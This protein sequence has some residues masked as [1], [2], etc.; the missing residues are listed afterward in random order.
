MQIYLGEDMES[1]CRG[2]DII[3]NDTTYTITPMEMMSIFNYYME[4]QKSRCAEHVWRDVE[5]ALL[6]AEYP[7]NV[8]L[9]IMAER[10]EAY[11]VLALARDLEGTQISIGPDIQRA[12]DMLSNENR[13]VIEDFYRDKKYKNA[14]LNNNYLNLS[15][16][17]AVPLNFALGEALCA[18]EPLVPTE[19]IERE[20]KLRSNGKRVQKYA[21][22]GFYAVIALYNKIHRNG[23]EILLTEEEVSTIIQT[24]KDRRIYFCHLE[25]ELYMFYK[26]TYVLPLI[27]NA[28]NSERK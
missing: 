25:Y 21:H 15:V 1:I 6:R 2:I 8:L 4:Q 19:K 7:L 13:T 9:S 3:R 5:S 11:R 22:K 14:G 26:Y 27:R 10:C 20:I 24:I 12:I 28:D 16:N 23:Q 18:L 17:E